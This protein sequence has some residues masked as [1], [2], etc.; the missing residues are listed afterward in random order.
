MIVRN[1]EA[2]DE[3]EKEPPKAPKKKKKR[4]VTDDMIAANRRNSTFSTGPKTESGR[5]NSRFN[6]TRHGLASRQIM[7]LEGED[8]QQFWQ[9]VDLW[10]TQRG[11]RTADERT[12]IAN[13]VYSVWVKARVINAQAHAYN[14]AVDTINHSFAG[15]KMA[16]VRDLLAGL[17]EKPEVT[18]A[19]VM[20][21]SYGCSLLI[22]EFTALSRRLKSHCSF[23]VSQ[24]EHALRLGGHRPKELFT[25]KVV[26]E[27]NRSYF[28]SLHGP[29]GFTAAQAADAL[30]SDRPDDLSEGEFERRLE[31]VITNLP[32]IEEG[33]AKLKRYVHRWIAQLTERK[34]LMEYREEK[35]KKAAIGKAA[36]DVSAAGQV[37]VRYAN[38]ADRR[39]NASMRLVLALKAERC[40]HGDGDGDLDEPETFHRGHGPGGKRRPGGGHT[41]RRR[42]KTDRSRGDG[43]GWP[44]NH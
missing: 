30:S 22:K 29:G 16:E 25:N 11:A 36:A 4:I 13:A 33:H 38:Q 9:E 3:A 41:G 2:V 14:D 20:N 27:F 6:G 17:N 24:R 8:P 44:G 35:Q 43:S 18:I 37:L 19:D 34:E 21:T 7:F 1:G 5:E 32:T 39:F 40:K 12:A 23:E 26:E 15:Q 28:G 31:R 10:C 42:R